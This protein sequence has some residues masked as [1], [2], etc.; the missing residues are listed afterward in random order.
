MPFFKIEAMRF[1]AYQKVAR[2]ANLIIAVSTTDADYLRKQFPN[3]RI[4]FVPCFHENNRITAEPENPII[5]YIMA[6]Y[7]LSRM[8]EPCYFSPSMFS[9]N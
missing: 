3:Q 4:E 9:A 5:F 6:S 1:Q 8:N 7:P 2:Y